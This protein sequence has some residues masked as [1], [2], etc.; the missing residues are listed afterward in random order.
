MP[1]FY[2]IIKYLSKGNNRFKNDAFDKFRRFAA[3][4]FNSNIAN[5]F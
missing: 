5:Q 1:L 3:F 2:S 4:N